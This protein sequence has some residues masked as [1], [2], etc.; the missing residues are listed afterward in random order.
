MVL[1]VEMGAIVQSLRPVISLTR[2]TYYQIICSVLLHIIVCS[3]FSSTWGLFC[4][5]HFKALIIPNKIKSVSGGWEDKLDFIH[6]QNKAD[7]YWL[8]RTTVV[9]PFTLKIAFQKIRLVFSCKSHDFYLNIADKHF[10]SILMQT[11][12]NYLL[13]FR[14]WVEKVVSIMKIPL[15]ENKKQK[16]GQ[17]SKK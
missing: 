17:T 14:F 15:V 11:V 1:T 12:K 3:T 8:L 7:S 6:V 16:V 13:E 5:Y 4:W 2:S 9:P 10:L